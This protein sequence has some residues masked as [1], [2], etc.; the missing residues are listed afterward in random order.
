MSRTVVVVGNLTSNQAW[1]LLCLVLPNG[2]EASEAMGHAVD[3]GIDFGIKHHV[4]Y[5]RAYHT[6]TVMLDLADD[7]PGRGN[8]P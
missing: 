4:E 1:W 5:S 6:F 8:L 2:T 7:L 3:S